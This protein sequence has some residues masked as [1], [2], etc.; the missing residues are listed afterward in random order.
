MPRTFRQMISLTCIYI[1][2]RPI[3]TI[4]KTLSLT[5]TL[6]AVAMGVP[7]ETLNGFKIDEPLVPSRLIKQGG[8]PRDGIPSI[9][10]P[11]FVT[12]G[13]AS[14]LRGTDK[15]LGLYHNDVAK[16]YPIRILNYHE[17]VN[18]RF[19][20][21]PVAVTFCPLC[22]TGIAFSA[23]TDHGP[24]NFGVSGLLY[25]S[26]VLMYDRETESLWSQI[27]GSAINGPSKGQAL[28]A[29][30]VLH[31]TWSDWWRR[32]PDTLILTEPAT[33]GR[34]YNVDPYLGY[35]KTNDL[36]FPVANRDNRYPA[37]SVVIGTV[38]LG[39]PYAW[40]FAELPSDQKILTDRVANTKIS[41]EYDHATGAAVV[42][43]SQGDE[44]PSFTVF[45]FAWIAF[46][47][48]TIVWQK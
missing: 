34:N 18:D 14:H 33:S 9:D 4:A 23:V 39:K 25:N 31:T 24:R 5:I 19:G 42:R 43:N 17:I 7:A 16:A 3:A 28:T 21:E 46:H 10:A 30:P 27:L 41:V 36:W 38:I 40:P 6:L 8:P 2:Y 11:Q 45:W 13:E 1:R 35:A 12:A 22:G 32:H 15:V 44:I 20:T 47:P 48:N 37:K 26:D 29:L